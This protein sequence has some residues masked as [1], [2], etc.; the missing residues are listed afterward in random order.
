[1]LVISEDE[2][3]RVLD[4]NEL[5]ETMRTALCELSA[6][7]VIQPLRGVIRIA[8]HNGWYGVMPAVFQ[9]VIGTKLVT[10][11]PQN[12]DRGLHTHNAVIHLFR[13]ETGEPLAVVGGRVITALR[14]AAVSALA[15]AEL[16]REDARVLAILG[17]GVQARSHYEALKLIRNFQDVRV[18][19]RT[20]EHAARF[21]AEIGATVMSAEKAVRNADV[22]VTATSSATPLLRGEWLRDGAHV[23]AIGAVG[24][25][26]RELDDHAM[27]N[28]AIIVES[29]EAALVESGDI[30]DSG[31]AIYSE[32]GELL[33]G[34]KPKPQSRTTVY[35]SL[36]VAVEDIAAA[37]LVY[38]KSPRRASSGQL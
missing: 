32:L 1:M 3:L 25:H 35:K 5:R 4:H 17:S 21:A 24:P 18:W 15:T 12:V 11:F 19:S 22:I 20:P 23:N 13:S 31:R 36:G 6:G 2:V 7:R 34:C 9:D 37:K 10:V 27:Q 33:T 29:R 14:T 38:D 30:I 28:A 26:M 8:G 16:S